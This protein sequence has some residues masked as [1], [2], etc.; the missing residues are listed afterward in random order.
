MKESWAAHALIGIPTILKH[1]IPCISDEGQHRESG[2]SVIRNNWTA[3]DGLRWPA[4]DDRWIPIILDVAT[5]INFWLGNAGN[6]RPISVLPI[7]RKYLKKLYMN[8]YT[9][10]LN[11]IIYFMSINMVSGNLCLLCT[12][13]YWITCNLCTTE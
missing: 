8:S 7:F 13:H 12:K 9:N 1:R 6:Y 5:T 2:T 10:I 4:T 3:D 11:K